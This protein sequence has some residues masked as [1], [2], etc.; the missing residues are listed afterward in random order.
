MSGETLLRCEHASLRY[1]SVDA[2]R[3]ATLAIA[4]GEIWTV[5]GPNGCGKSSLLRV[6]ARLESPPR[7]GGTVAYASAATADARELA[8]LRAFVPQ[9]PEVSAGFSAREVVRLGRHAVGASEAAV[10]RALAEVGLSERA[11][12]PFHTLSGGERQRIAI[13]R[14]FAQLDAGGVLLL[15]EPFSGIDPAE[16]AR[17]AGALAQRAQRGAVVLSLHDPGLARAIATHAA[18][19][20]GGRIVEQGRADRILTPGTLSA[21]YGHPMRDRDGWIVPELGDRAPTPR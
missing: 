8:R 19:M 14:A 1:G 11:E 9:R 15:D 7:S 12:L 20:R 18:V 16:I 4:R 21:A 17:I 10:E 13:A 3:D 2:L 6:L 5:V